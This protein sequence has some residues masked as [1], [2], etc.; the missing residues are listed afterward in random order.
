MS[1]LVLNNAFIDKLKDPLWR[2]E[3]LYHIQTDDGQSLLFK[4]NPMQQ[5]LFS[6]LH[7]RNLIA[8][9]R[10]LGMSTF[11]EVF[12][13]DF[14]L[15][16]KNKKAAIVAD[17]KENASKLFEK[18]EF[19]WKEFRQD[20]KDYLGLQCLSDSASKMEFSNGSSVVVGTTIHA[21]TYQFLHI[22]E[23][24]PLAA[25]SPDK[26]AVVMKSALPTVHN[27]PNTY[28]FIESTSE[29]E[30]NE[31]H[32]R[33]LDAQAVTERA[34]AICP[35]NPSRAL[36]TMEYRFFFF[37]WWQDPKYALSDEEATYVQIPHDIQ[38]YFKEMEAKLKITFTINQK[39]WYTLQA[40]AL[41]GRMKE[42]FPSYA[43]ESFLSSGNKLFDADIIKAKLAKEA[44]EAIEIDGSWKIYVPYRRGHRYAIGADVS[45]GVGGHHS[46]A[47]IIDFDT[48][49]VV[50]TYMDNRI[51]PIP[52]A[53]ELAR[54][55]NRYGTCLIAPEANSIG[56]TTV[57]KLAE[58]YPNVYRY[59]I[60][61][62]TEDKETERL[63][64]LTNAATKGKMV[65]ALKD[66][67][68]EEEKPLKVPDAVILREALAYKKE[69]V[70]ETETVNRLK[71]MTS[72][73]DLLIAT[74]I[75]WAMMPYAQ[76]SGDQ[77][78]PVVIQTIHE[79]RERVR[80]SR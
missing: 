31:F 79:R 14:L 12:L 7:W 45:M 74:A 73:S 9:A 57:H 42:Q 75:A 62:L 39:A 53:F 71:G 47:T 44:R 26:A 56:H 72:H 68:E 70:T 8:K 25:E 67:M 43:E 34:Q 59:H 51:A 10:Q 76:F 32:D 41:K 40:K 69:S 65:Y 13:L 61:G 20:V 1:K 80:S 38:Q 78:E 11:I 48:N 6:Q 36:L 35:D 58:I 64:W 23:L 63:G 66:A 77:D 33:A 15:F 28:V 52:F 24:G 46:T 37:A 5:I 22:S 19:A 3:H 49:E 29:G 50:A 17:K 21:G 18:V 27:H 30:G 2:L 55:G 60:Q 16:H 4:L 54:G